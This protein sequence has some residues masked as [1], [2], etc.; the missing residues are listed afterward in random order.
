MSAP[1]MPDHLDYFNM[2]RSLRFMKQV[3][4]MVTHPVS[5]RLREH[6]CINPNEPIVHGGEP[7][8]PMLDDGVANGWFPEFTKFDERDERVC[9][10]IP[11]GVRPSVPR[12]T[13][14]HYETFRE[15]RLMPHD[16]RRCTTC[17]ARR[18]LESE[19]LSQRMAYLD[20][21]PL[22]M[23]SGAE[24]AAARGAIE[25]ALG[26]GVSVDAMLADELLP[27]AD[28]A[29]P[30]PPCNGIRDIILTGEVM[31][32]CLLVARCLLIAV[33]ACSRCRSTA[34]RGTCS[35]STAACGA[36][37]GSSRSCAP[38]CGGLTSA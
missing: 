31:R 11:P 29:M 22:D 30:L 15:G 28:E 38:P 16:E 18:E 25:E 14:H 20:T 3:P 36:G 8:R 21:E 32:L 7:D 1:Q 12:G 6:H 9:A 17:I 23:G 19:E 13:R 34:R 35:G 2:I 4:R 26:A 27:R 24:I 33:S 5:F 10:S 37:T